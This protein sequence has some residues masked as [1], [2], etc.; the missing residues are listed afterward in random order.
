MSNT[1]R[2]IF[3][4]KQNTKTNEKDQNISIEK[5]GAKIEEVKNNTSVL[6]DKQNTISKVEVNT[7]FPKFK[8][9]T[10]GSNQINFNFYK[11]L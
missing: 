4:E 6:A 9:E 5:I 7:A 3:M 10:F 1:T 2:W 8:K 11:R